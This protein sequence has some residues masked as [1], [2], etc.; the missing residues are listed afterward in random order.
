[1]VLNA[2]NKPLGIFYDQ[3]SWGT[4]GSSHMFLLL[5]KP[6]RY[7]QTSGR[8][9][10]CEM[11]NALSVANLVSASESIRILGPPRPMGFHFE[12]FMS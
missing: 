2:F 9:T 1:M 8:K 4:L 11:Y 10:R 5:P 12:A 7:P 3:K 6:K